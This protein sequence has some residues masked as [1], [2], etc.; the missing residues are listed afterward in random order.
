MGQLAGPT[1]YSTFAL[2]FHL[3]FYAWRPSPPIARGSRP[4]P[5]KKRGPLRESERVMRLETRQAKRCYRPDFREQMLPKS[6]ED[7]IYQAQISVMATGVDDRVW[8]GYSLVDVY[9]EGASHQATREYYTDPEQPRDP[10]SRGKYTADRPFWNPSEWFL[11][12]L[13]AQIHQ[14]SVEMNNSVIEI[15]K[16]IS[17]C[18][19]RPRHLEFLR[20][21]P[22]RGFVLHPG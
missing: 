1:G 16:L 4:S 8:T 7:S 18:V 22:T 21:S 14:V 3:S 10:H 5:N 6:G 19:S 9:F 20:R 12:A 2:E 17:P 11:V 15:K 13:S